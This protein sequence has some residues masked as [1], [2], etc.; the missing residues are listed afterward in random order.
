MNVM[1]MLGRKSKWD[2][3]RDAAVTTATSAGARHAGKVTGKVTLGLAG[4]AAAATLASAAVS[5]ARQHG[6]QS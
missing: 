5:A 4:G 1:R 3:L 6:S 2:R